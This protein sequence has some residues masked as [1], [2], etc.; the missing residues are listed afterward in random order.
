LKS[1]D[2]EAAVLQFVLVEMVDVERFLPISQDLLLLLPLCLLLGALSGV[3]LWESNVNISV[4]IV[5]LTQ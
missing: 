3:T 1:V 5:M 4:N 2:A